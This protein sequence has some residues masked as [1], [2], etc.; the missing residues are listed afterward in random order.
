MP[1]VNRPLRLILLAVLA[2]LAAALLWLVLGV[3]HSAITL[4]QDLRALPGWAQSI[5]A[6]LLV[7]TICGLAW[8]ATWLVGPRRRKA[9]VVAAPT[10]GE[11]EQ[12]IDALKQRS[13]ETAE[14]EAELV[15]LD[16]R[17]RAEQ[18]YVAVFGEISAGK[19]SVIRALAP[20]AAPQV[21]VLGGTTR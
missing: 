18:L 15:E 12:R 4:W 17:A 9:V 6:V 5:V 10:R 21:D 1:P 14:L 3:L 19:S 8:V 20:G 16:R 13:A 7:G 11:V 2:L